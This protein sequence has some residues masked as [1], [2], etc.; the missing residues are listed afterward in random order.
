MKTIIVIEDSSRVNFGGGQKMTIMVGNIL[1]EKFNLRFVDYTDGS[2]YARMVKAQFENSKF[3]NVGHSAVDGQRSL[4]LWLKM[5]FFSVVFFLKDA[6]VILEGLNPQDCI[7][8]ST[9]KRALIMAAFLKWKYG[10]PFIHH[11]HLVE[12]PKSKYFFFAKRLFRYADEVFCVSK[13]VMRSINTDNCHLVYNPSLN[14]RGKKPAK[15]VERFV[16]A[17]VGSLIPIKGVEYFLAASN[18]C[19]DSIEFQVYGDGPLRNKLEDMGFRQVVFKG[20]E[21]NI[22]DRYYDDIDILVVPTV[23]QEAL[24]LVVVD[25][26]SVGIPVI[27]TSPGGQAEIVKDGVDGFHVPMRN[28]QAIAASIMRL[29]SD[30]NLYNK[31]SEASFLSFTP[32]SYL[33]FRQKVA[34]T[35][36]EVSNI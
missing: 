31:M 23:I 15:N 34:Q 22:I 32:F 4:W 30:L 5:I 2:Q 18:L 26:K 27:V 28:A 19:S 21:N 25:A 29:T 9:N 3:I 33:A 20:F 24:S 17:F 10:I 13:T 6:K 16:V 36:D 35:F 11:A 8:Y 14:K 1:K 7:C 12:N